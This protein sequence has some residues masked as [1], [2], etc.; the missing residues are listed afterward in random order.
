MLTFVTLWKV[1]KYP[2]AQLY[3]ERS[4]KL[5]NQIITS[6]RSSNISK[7]SSKNLYGIIVMGLAAL[8]AINHQEIK[9]SVKLCKEAVKQLDGKNVLARP[10]LLDFI[11]LLSSH[12][13]L[14]L[15][16]PPFSNVEYQPG[17]FHIF[18]SDDSTNSLP[19]LKVRNVS[20]WLINEKYEKVL[21]ITTFVPL[22]SPIAPWIDTYELETAQNRKQGSVSEGYDKAIGQKVRTVMKK[23]GRTESTP[24]PRIHKLE[25]GHE[26]IRKFSQDPNDRSFTT[27]GHGRHFMF[28]LSSVDS[29]ARAMPLELVP[30][31]PN[32]QAVLPKLHKTVI[33]FRNIS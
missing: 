14:E 1:R 17:K 26:R 11:K 3:L 22:I 16:L 8:K 33:N 2:E 5:I 28:E 31:E 4:A 15:V 18:D 19:N 29:G 21:F 6:R 12:K 27:S 9:K 30:I 24:R 13:Q 20:D 32:N 10:L 7:V 25:V 23:N